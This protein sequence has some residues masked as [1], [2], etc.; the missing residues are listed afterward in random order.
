MSNRAY[1]RVHAQA[2]KALV[3]AEGVGF[4]L[5][6]RSVGSL[7]IVLRRPLPQGFHT[8]PHPIVIWRV[9]VHRPKFDRYL[10]GF[11][12]TPRSIAICMVIVHRPKSDRY[13]W[14]VSHDPTSDLYLLGF[15]ASPQI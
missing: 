12:T 4:H 2:H 13:L 10:E 14:G 9:F 6:G 15:R 8:T 7:Q 5:R 3:S 1:R 11:R